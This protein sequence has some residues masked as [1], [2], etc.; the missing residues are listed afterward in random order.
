M[1]AYITTYKYGSLA[2]AAEAISLNLAVRE[3]LKRNHHWVC[4]W[5][6]IELL[7]EM[8]KN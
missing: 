6:I 8:Q 4:F 7:R 5:I 3:A 2:E 1:S